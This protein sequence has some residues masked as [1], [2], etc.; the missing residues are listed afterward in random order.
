MTFGDKKVFA[1]PKESY[2]EPDVGSYNINRDPR[3][4]GPTGFKKFREAKQRDEGTPG[5]GAYNIESSKNIV[6]RKAPSCSFG[7]RYS[8]G[9]HF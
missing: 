4:W 7:F 1:A 5:A 6:K 3:S 2:F 8:K 9:N